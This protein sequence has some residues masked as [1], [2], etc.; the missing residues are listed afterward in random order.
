MDKNTIVGFFLI[1]LI[2]IG[3]A[4]LNRP[5]Q[6]QLE[7]QRYIRD[8]LQH[9]EAIRKFEEEAGLIEKT[10][11]TDPF[12]EFRDS[13]SIAA[14]TDDEEEDKERILNELYGVMASYVEG[15]QNFYIIENEK[16]KMTLTN[17]G[18][19]IYSVELK[20]YNTYNGNPLILFDGPDN[21]FGFPFVH[22]TRNFHTDDLY[23]GI[24]EKDDSRIIFELKS[25]SDEFL[26]FIYELPQDDY[27]S[28]FYI[29]SRNMG[30]IIATPRGS[31]EFVWSM[32]IPSSEKGKK[33]EQQYSSVYYKYFGNEVDWISMGKNGNDEFRTKMN[34]VAFKSQFFSSVFIADEGFAGGRVSAELDNRPESPF[35]SYHFAE[36]AVPVEGI[37][38]NTIPFRFY[39][40]PNHFYTLQSYGQDLELTRMIALGWGIFGWINKFIVIPVFNYLEKHIVNYG[41][42]ILILTL[43]IK[44][45]L[46]PLTYKSY[47]SSA[48][49]KVLKPQIDEI[50]KKIPEDKKLERQQAT[51]SLYKKAGVNPMGGCI[52]MLLQLPVLFAMFRFLPASIELRQKSFLWAEDLSAYDSIL[53][54]PFTIPMY[55][56]HVSLFTLLMSVV[57]VISTKFNMA[58]QPSQ[59]QMPGMKMMMYMMPVMLL[60]FLN[61]F[62]SGLTY[63]YFIS[64]LITILQ[65]LV[66][67]QFIDEKKLLATLNE[68][69][70]KPVKKSGFA[71][72]LEMMAKKQNQ[73]R[74]QAQSQSSK[75]TGQIRNQIQ[76]ANRNKPIKQPPP[77]KKQK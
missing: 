65:T 52:P 58:T 25:E 53:D 72:R 26:A 70:K 40:G 64:T 29:Q 37:G 69:Q 13:D 56:D 54:L 14:V 35:L 20:N 66:I 15:E 51:M 75:P 36:M 44:L 39:F 42:I 59:Q 57:T 27:M 67:K 34:W 30:R 33:F 24:R 23:F 47:Q 49:M 60:V 77:N 4:L 21:K 16:I 71:H 68:N 61:S 73:L 17:K 9:V 8:S 76:A 18:G 74:N 62:A 41:I 50:N 45:I 11:K 10:A 48:K 22:N 31:M 3:W 1:A 12:H 28:R 19:K 38:D 32:K 2:L 5:S 63:Y 55:G 43:L 7:R 46:F 6:E